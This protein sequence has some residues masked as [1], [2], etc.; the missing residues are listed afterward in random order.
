MEAG[1]TCCR[2]WFT[3]NQTPAGQHTFLLEAGASPAIACYENNLRFTG[4]VIMVH[5]PTN[6]TPPNKPFF[7]ESEDP[8]ER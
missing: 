8:G 2:R 4:K 6:V 5:S 7:L 1:A 3:G